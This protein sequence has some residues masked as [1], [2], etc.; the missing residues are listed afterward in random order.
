MDLEEVENKIKHIMLWMEDINR[1]I[2][3]LKN[4]AKNLER[5]VL[6]TKFN[7]DLFLEL[8]KFGINLDDM[9]IRVLRLEKDDR[10]G[11]EGN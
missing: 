9:N 10:T 5:T 11:S 3:R 1:D 4:T 2:T 6:N 8:R 7:N